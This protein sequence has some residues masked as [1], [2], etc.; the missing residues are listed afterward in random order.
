MAFNLA[1]IL[2]VLFVVYVPHSL[3]GI[4]RLFVVPV[5]E[6]G[7]ACLDYYLRLSPDLQ[8]LVYTSVEKQPSYERNLNYLGRIR[9]FNYTSDLEKTL[10]I[11]L[12]LQTRNNGTLFIHVYLLPRGETETRLSHLQNA[13]LS[14][15]TYPLTHYQV[16]TVSTF[17]LLRGEK[18]HDKLHLP[19]TH[20]KKVI[21]FKMLT[22]ID[23]LP[24]NLLPAELEG[25]ARVRGGRTLL[26]IM[27]YD[28]LSDQL[29]NLVPCENKTSIEVTLKYS[30]VGLG[31]FRFMILSEMAFASIQVYG[32]TEKDLDQL[33]S[34]F[35]DGNKIYLLCVTIV[36]ASLHMV[37]DILA[38]KTDVNFWRTRTTL[39]GLSRKTVMWRAFSQIV[40]FLFLQEES[41]SLLI[42]V[43]A[44]F[45]L[46]IELWKVLKVLR[47]DLKNM[48]QSGQS[49]S[50][51]ERRTETIDNEGMRYLLYILFPLCIGG[52]V[53]SLL[54]DHHKSWYSWTINSLVNGV[55]AFGFLFMLP[56]LFINY[57]MKSVAQLPWRSFMYK[58]F[59][60]FVDDLF[61]FIIEMP[62]AHRIA[63][64]RDDLVFLVY[65]Y[66]RWL[67]PVDQ[68]RIDDAS[69]IGEVPD[70]LQKPAVRSSK[71]K[72]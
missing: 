29:N 46:L 51:A 42:T 44:F 12:P 48:S 66:Q 41:S 23:E 24:Q 63:C 57:K 2:S 36:V 11:A 67:Y 13:V 71:K 9:D 35:S 32:F 3:Y 62:T 27:H 61:A 28:T 18:K 26:P 64:F 21:G 30:S 53:Y 49:L 34:L 19:V 43:P 20:V 31:K 17:D 68:N 55:Y 1:T 7:Q 16:P 10:K 14:G 37:F 60:T 40:I 45:S 47:F 25:F 50:E 56:Q 52:A 4:W 15:F 8:L 6:P 58:A 22:G 38:L 69:S 70:D 65:L 33:K 39:A 54:Y 5:C 59:N 72:N